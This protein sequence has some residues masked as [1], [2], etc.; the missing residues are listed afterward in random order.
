VTSDIGVLISWDTVPWLS[1]NP[2]WFREQDYLIY[3]V[4][5]ITQ[6]SRRLSLSPSF[7]FFLL[8]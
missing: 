1:P 2:G 7:S 5:R 6:E 3:L 4:I 8:L